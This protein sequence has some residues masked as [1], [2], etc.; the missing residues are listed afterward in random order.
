[1]KTAITTTKIPLRW[2][3]VIV[4]MIPKKDDEKKDPKNYRPISL[5]SCLARLCER[6]LLIE[7]NDHLKKTIS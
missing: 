2:K 4:K 5:T 3:K 1:M 7:I 6:F